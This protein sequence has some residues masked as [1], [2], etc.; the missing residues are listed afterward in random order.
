[1]LDCAAGCGVVSRTGTWYTYGA[2]KLGQ[3]RDNARLFLRDNPDIYR[4][5]REKVLAAKMPAAPG[6]AE[7]EEDVGDRRGFEAAPGAKRAGRPP[8]PAAARKK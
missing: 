7:P 5:I 4:E 2:T 3:G 1:M 8:A 6:P